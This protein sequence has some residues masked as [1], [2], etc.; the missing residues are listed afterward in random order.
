MDHGD[1]WAVQ[2]H[3]GCLI[4]TMVT[5]IQEPKGCL[6]WTMAMTIWP[7]AWPV[8]Y[9]VPSAEEK[10]SM[11]SQ[12]HDPLNCARSDKERWLHEEGTPTCV[13]AHPEPGA[14]T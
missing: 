13:K 10:L 9:L 6:I 11:S 12:D 2:V 8:I 3:K 7:M 1:P 5:L 14:A 4:R